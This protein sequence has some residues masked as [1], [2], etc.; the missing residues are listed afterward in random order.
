MH[1]NWTGMES[2]NNGHTREV[3]QR[4]WQ[5]WANTCLDWQSVFLCKTSLR[6]VLWL[7]NSVPRDLYVFY[8]KHLPKV[9]ENLALLLGLKIGSYWAP[10]CFS[11]GEHS[12]HS[13]TI[14]SVFIVK[15]LNHPDRVVWK[16][17]HVTGFI[18]LLVQNVFL[19]FQEF[20]QSEQVSLRDTAYVLQGFL[21]PS[22]LRLKKLFG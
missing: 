17:S 19:L 3:C 18:F 6:L 10:I 21:L 11:W 4:N 5:K 15:I 8:P 12:R 7:W 20:L 2:W 14:S 1:N 22:F 13:W 9:F 16:L